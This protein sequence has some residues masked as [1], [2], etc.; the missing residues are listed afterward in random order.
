VTEVSSTI[1]MR[2]EQYGHA[3]KY[4]IALWIRDWANGEMVR[5]EQQW[6]LR[7]EIAVPD[8]GAP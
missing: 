3:K 8:F 7:A 6:V 1:D 5:A 2:C 4:F